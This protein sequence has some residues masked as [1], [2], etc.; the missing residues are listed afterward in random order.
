MNHERAFPPPPSDLFGGLLEQVQM[1]R[2]FSD[3][4]TFVDLVPVRPAADIMEDFRRRPPIGRAQLATFVADNFASE[5][6]A[7]AG[8]PSAKSTVGPTLMRQHIRDLWGQLIRS[9]RDCVYG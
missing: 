3:G 9:D 8:H 4:K 1:Q 5:Q 2:L 7:N 6:I